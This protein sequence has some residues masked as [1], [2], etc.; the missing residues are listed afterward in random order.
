MPNNMKKYFHQRYTKKQGQLFFSA[1]AL[2]A[3]IYSCT[4]TEWNVSKANNVQ[5]Q[6]FFQRNDTL[7]TFYTQI[8]GSL[9][10]DT[11]LNKVIE[12]FQNFDSKANI[13][14]DIEK[15]IW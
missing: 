11:L 7:K 13:V 2:V 3:I 14:N 10:D 1:I 8:N 5:G 6:T 12:H 4:K 15:K 9:A